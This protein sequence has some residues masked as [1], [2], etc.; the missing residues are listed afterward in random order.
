MHE[1]GI[2]Q[3]IVAI[4]SEHAGGRPVKRVVLEVGR[5]AG[6]MTDSIRFC[7]DV[8]TAGTPLEGAVLEIREIE[9][10]ARCEACGAEFVQATLI[11]PCACGS[12]AVERLA[13]Q[14]L[15]IREYELD[16]APETAPQN[17]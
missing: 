11:T 15:N 14:E 16:V 1:L 10:R 17:A 2:T 12:Y 4:V 8:C 9:A 7:F 13:G 5:L 6:V 3:S